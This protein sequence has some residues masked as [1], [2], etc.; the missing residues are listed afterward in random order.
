MSVAERLYSN[1][2]TKENKETTEEKLFRLGRTYNKIMDD[3]QRVHDV[4]TLLQV[5]NE[6]NEYANEVGKGSADVMR[7]TDKLNNR[8]RELKTE[9]DENIRALNTE[10]EKIKNE[11]YIEP[12]EKL[13]ELNVQ[14]EHKTL[15]FLVQLGNN[16]DRGTENRRRIGNF[17]AHADRADAIALMRIASFPEFAQCFT[18]KHKQ[19]IL[20]K[21]KNP[22]EI[23]FDRNKE[24]LLQEKG[25][26][27]GEIYM[28]N[29]HLRNA[30]KKIGNEE[31]AYYFEK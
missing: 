13:Q 11:K 30:L 20:E 3:I 18:A 24:L 29:F 28:R 15:Q 22:A 19:I 2:R 6:I 4:K 8:V 14:S 17:V 27:L 31:N 9:L 12:A 26:Q 10:I 25:K 23:L 16:N 1:N 7:Q 5:R 21:S